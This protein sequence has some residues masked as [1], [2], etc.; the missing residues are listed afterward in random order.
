[1]R[2]PGLGFLCAALGLA[3]A[4]GGRAREPE[5]GQQGAAGAIS[6]AGSAGTGQQGA[7]GAISSAGS[8]GADACELGRAS[9]KRDQDELVVTTNDCQQDSD[10]GTLWETNACVSTCGTPVPAA[11]ID[12]LAEWLRRSASLSCSSCPPIPIPPCAPPGPVKCIDGRCRE[13]S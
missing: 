13:G 1:M 11:I 6:S 5:T 7:A 8:A 10:C 9:Y 4:C 12:S 3:T 2:P